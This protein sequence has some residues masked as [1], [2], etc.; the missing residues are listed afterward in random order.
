MNKFTWVLAWLEQRHINCLYC[1]HL[2][3]WVLPQLQWWS[4]IF[5]LR[6]QIPN[7]ITT[8]LFVQNTLFFSLDITGKTTLGKT[9]GLMW[10]GLEENLG[11]ERMCS[12]GW[13]T[14]QLHVV[15]QSSSYTFVNNLLLLH[16]NSNT[17][18]YICTKKVSCSNTFIY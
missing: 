3:T 2:F 10:V 4:L 12:T 15:P 18:I 17:V 16:V 9:H 13:D 14:V 5:T 8:R 1:P 11:Q 6:S 7:N